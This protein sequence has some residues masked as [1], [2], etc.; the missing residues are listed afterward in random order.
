MRA[1][2]CRTTASLVSDALRTTF[3]FG[4]MIHILS[5]GRFTLARERRSLLLW[6]NH[7]W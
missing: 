1:I 4:F 2:S 3:R 5:L 6:C 7:V